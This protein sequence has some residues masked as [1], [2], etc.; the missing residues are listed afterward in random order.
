MFDIRK[1]EQLE[2]G[3]A[4][5]RICRVI[6]M[7]QSCLLSRSQVTYS[8]LYLLVGMYASYFFK[9]LA[10]SAFT[11]PADPELP[12]YRSSIQTASHIP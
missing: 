7:P 8:H 6:E 5:S 12:S 1:N 4:A 2:P 3:Q 10:L 9:R 11:I